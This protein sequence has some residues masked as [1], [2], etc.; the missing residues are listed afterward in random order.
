[1]SDGPNVEERIIRRTRSKT[2]R[3][4]NNQKKRDKRM[5]NIFYEAKWFLVVAAIGIPLLLGVI[6]LLG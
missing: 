2:R 1:M 5:A 6:Y 3:R 4:T